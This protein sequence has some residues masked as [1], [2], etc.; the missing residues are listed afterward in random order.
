MSWLPRIL[1]GF[2]SAL[3]C[4]S[5]PLLHAQSA[6]AP[7]AEMVDEART[8]LAK[9]SAGDKEVTRAIVLL[10]DAARA[11]NNDASF[12]LAGIY[13]EGKLLPA[14]PARAILFARQGAGRGDARCMALMGDFYSR[15]VGVSSNP[16]EARTWMRKAADAGSAEAAK[17]LAAKGETR[18][19]APV[20]PS[21]PEPPRTRP[22]TDVVVVP[23]KPTSANPGP[24]VAKPVAKAVEPKPAVPAIPAEPPRVTPAAPPSK[25]PAVAHAPSTSKPILPD[26]EFRSLPPD[27]QRESQAFKALGSDNL[28][29]GAASAGAVSLAP[30]GRPAATGAAFRELATLA[31]HDYLAAATMAKESYRMM[32]GPMDARQFQQ[33]NAKWAPI[34]QNPTVALRRYLNSLNPPLAEF[35][36][37]RGQ[38]VAAAEEFDALV[39]EARAAAAFGNEDG[40]RLLLSQAATV[41]TQLLA[42]QSRM[43]VLAKLIRA[44]G[45][46]PNP[47]EQKVR[48]RRKHDDAIAQIKELAGPGGCWVLQEVRKGRDATSLD[49]AG[50]P[51]DW[52]LSLFDFQDLVGNHMRVN[53]YAQEIDPDEYKERRGEA[54]IRRAAFSCQTQV[55]WTEPPT[56]LVPLPEGDWAEVEAFLSP[57]GT[58]GDYRACGAEM[59]QDADLKNR[60][61]LARSLQKKGKPGVF[62][63]EVLVP[64][65]ITSEARQKYWMPSNGARLFAWIEV[66]LGKGTAAAPTALRRQ[67]HGLIFRKDQVVQGTHY[68]R[69]AAPLFIPPPPAASSP[70]APRPELSFNLAIGPKFGGFGTPCIRYVYRWDPTGNSIAPLARPDAHEVANLDELER[71]GLPGAKSVVAKPVPGKASPPPPPPP[72]PDPIEAQ[73]KSYEENIARLQ[74]DIDGYRRSLVEAKDAKSR[75]YFERWI[76]GR[77]ADIQ[78]ERDRIATLRTGNYVHTPTPWDDFCQRRSSELMLE[79]SRKREYMRRILNSADRVVS[80]L[81][82]GMQPEARKELQSGLAEAVP[83]GDPAAARKVVDKVLARADK[84]NRD[85][86]AKYQAAG[87]AAERLE[88]GARAVKFVCDTSLQFMSMGGGRPLL[89]AYEATTGYV[90][91]G[92]AKAVE[93]SARCYSSAVDYT[94][95]A[96]EGYDEGGVEGAVKNVACA[97]VQDKVVEK[98]AG[99]LF[100]GGPGAPAKAGTAATPGMPARRA[101][102]GFDADAVKFRKEVALG[103]EQVKRFTEAQE[104]LMA[105]G[106]SGTDPATISRLQADARN[107]A[108]ELNSSPMAKNV[109]KYQVEGPVAQAFDTHVRTA[110]AEIDAL[111]DAT[112]RKAK[113]NMDQVVVRDFR[114]ESS[115]GTVNMDRD[116]GLDAA[117]TLALQGGPTVRLTCNGNHRSVIE[118]EKAMSEAYEAA[119]HK[120][121]GR[122]A[123]SAWQLVT[124]SANKEAFKDV[125]VLSG[126]MSKA[127]KSWI[128]QTADV[129]T[130]KTTVPFTEKANARFS[131]WLKVQESAR[132]FGKELEKKILP[133]LKDVKPKA[134]KGTPE[135]KA[136]SE[137]MEAT[138]K[139][140]GE[141]K[142]LCDDFGKGRIED[143]LVFRDRFAELTGGKDLTQVAGEVGTILEG[144]VKF[145]K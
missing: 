130:Y 71:S 79:E 136:Q 94:F 45:D 44:I 51:L 124:S 20:V 47:L 56:R 59:F 3:A 140:L 107:L 100:S 119:Y 28:W 141:I 111:A 4:I 10:S 87:D 69:L 61:N 126:D 14:V 103:K 92:I 42:Y 129:I 34:M 137:R 25:A 21:R 82:Q 2:V 23:T 81:P 33:F 8:I 88:K 104:R 40:T 101:P 75:E 58:D 105:A 134:A 99:R 138:I 135:Y 73:V 22:A 67:L 13:S 30:R 110:Y 131:H 60:R 49:P 78:L 115:L 64:E 93:D 11:G 26:A 89:Y 98:V 118:W 74:Q 29:N 24:A 128:G 43:V 121:T 102:G 90:E 113:W 54:P 144:A 1:L 84:C 133:V 120:V 15:G 41:R 62:G 53:A 76:M 70:G 37:L 123:E 66:P 114:N 139:H 127:S 108:L 122:S 116:Y 86:F 19:D 72:P 142:A 112:M 35:Q 46:P 125:A 106:R 48:A 5:C 31:D 97:W 145:G 32:L 68:S 95:T 17:W 96:L 7:R 52:R 57:N 50:R 77:E 27:L 83:T 12:L 38:V 39:D 36:C 18:V 132:G 91:G 80:L 63:L 9:P 117:R 143:P 6:P 16:E 65:W 55:W 109:L 85:D